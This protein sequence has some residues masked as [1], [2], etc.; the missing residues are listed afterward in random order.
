MKD[1]RQKT[2]D[3]LR[4]DQHRSPGNRRVTGFLVGLILLATLL[5]ILDSFP[6]PH[7]YWRLSAVVNVAITLLFSAEY[8]LRVWTAPLCYPDKTPARARL[9]YIFSPMALI[10]LLSIL[11]FYLLIF[12]NVDFAALRTLRLLRLFVFFKF[13]RYFHTLDTIGQVIRT[14]KRELITSMVAVFS[15]MM[16]SSA[17]IYSIEG[18]VQ[19]EKFSNVLSGLWWAISTL[20]TIGYGDIYPITAIGKVLAAVVAVLGVGL[21]AVPTGII[22][23]GFVEVMGKKQEER[24]EKLR[25]AWQPGAAESEGRLPVPPVFPAVAPIPGAEAE[26]R[27]LPGEAAAF[28]KTGRRKGPQNGCPRAAPPAAGAMGERKN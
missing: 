26:Q 28:A 24:A 3:L 25:N 13:N 4:V 8:L 19:P 20:L 27:P 15:L 1:L 14:K 9:R 17:L 10:D 6:M 21:I 5:V 23:A 12:T 2:Y 11:P 16:I 22:S 18:Q 7:W